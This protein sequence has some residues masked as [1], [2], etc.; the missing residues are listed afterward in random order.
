MK[1]WRVA[2]AGIALTL[3][4][5]R[6]R[7]A[8]LPGRYGTVPVPEAMLAVPETVV[9]GGKL[10]AANCAI[11]HGV[12]GD[13]NGLRKEGLDPPPRDF[14]NSDWRKQTSPRRVFFVIKEG[15]RGTAMPSWKFL[16]D[17]DTWALVAYVRSISGKD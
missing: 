11:C 15:E 3:A 9:R 1:G 13:G 4:G 16:S 7:E 14:T 6:A 12:R 5:C 10:F 2:M 8:G 17:D